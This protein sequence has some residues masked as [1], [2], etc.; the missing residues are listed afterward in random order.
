LLISLGGCGDAPAEC[1]TLADELSFPLGFASYE[2]AG[3]SAE[4]WRADLT[5]ALV[6]AIAYSG[7]V[8][9]PTNPRLIGYSEIGGVRVFDYELDSRIDGATIPFG[10]L[11]PSNVQGTEPKD[12]VMVLHGHGET[13]TAAFDERSSMHNIGG[14]L[15][16]RGYVVISV[17]MRSF[18]AFKIDDLGHEEYIADLGDGEYVGQVLSDNV[19]VARAARS[20]FP[21]PEVASF[22]VFGHSFGGYI[23]LHIGALHPWVDQ[24]MSSG[25]FAPYG[26][27]NTDFHHAC[28]DIL[29]IEGLFEI[30]D[31]AALI[32]PRRVDLFFGVR[33]TLFTAASV[34]A[35]RRLERLYEKLGGRGLADLHVNPWLGHEVDV[36]RVLVNLPR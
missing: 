13:V 32:A 7:D 31:T 27:I 17:E 4:M 5:D 28:Q 33:D 25:H 14:H 20:L 18:G 3:K 9:A 10:L 30:Y 6:D 35:H 12:V 29:A 11:I 19:Q 23:A 26:C 24:T 21:A 16:D 22:T 2:L 8:G 36:E 15:L 1:E 34:E